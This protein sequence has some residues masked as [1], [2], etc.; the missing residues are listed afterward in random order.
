MAH[1][2]F[3]VALII[4]RVAKTQLATPGIPCA[5]EF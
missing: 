4:E 2:L 5:Q 3:T 1:S